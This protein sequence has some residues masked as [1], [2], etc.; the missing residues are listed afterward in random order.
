MKKNGKGIPL[1]PGNG[2]GD[3][4]ENRGYSNVTPFHTT[5]K[6]AFVSCKKFANMTLI[7]IAE[8]EANNGPG[9]KKKNT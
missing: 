5:L 8:L 9:K 1:S 4:R 3:N 7:P 2:D 6:P